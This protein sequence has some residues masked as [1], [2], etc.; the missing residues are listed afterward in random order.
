MYNL[1]I[2]DQLCDKQNFEAT[3]MSQSS[4]LLLNGHTTHQHYLKNGQLKY[5]VWIKHIL[6]ALQRGPNPF[7]HS[8]SII[9][10]R[11][12]ANSI[13]ALVGVV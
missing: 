8:F 7:R 9:K 6:Y 2:E 12:R 4:H 11:D 10:I 3:S 1:I 13:D 5:I